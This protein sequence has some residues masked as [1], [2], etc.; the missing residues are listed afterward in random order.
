MNACSAIAE[1]ERG[2]A[3][4]DDHVDERQIVIPQAMFVNKF[5]ENVVD[6]GGA[7]NV[8]QP[9]RGRV[10]EAQVFTFR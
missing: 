5:S 9:R 1:G 8:K 6:A 3:T 10:D 2:A 4:R 7:E